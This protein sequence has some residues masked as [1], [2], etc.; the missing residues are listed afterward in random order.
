MTDHAVRRCAEVMH[1]VTPVMMRAMFSEL[2]RRQPQGVTHAQIRALMIV[3]EHHGLSLSE[4]AEH[5]GTLLPAASKL[6]D[7]LVER[8]FIQRDAVAGDRRR[9]ALTLT[10]RGEATLVEG[11][12]RVLEVLIEQL[13]PLT[14]EECAVV[15]QAYQ[16]LGALFRPHIEAPLP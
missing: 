10:P 11:H 13:T 2:Q 4:F 14:A 1:E 15:E 8:G 5:F 6:V 16:I 9:V 3:R 12:A 7:L